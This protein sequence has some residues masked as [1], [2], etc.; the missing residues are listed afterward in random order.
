M[1]ADATSWRRVAFT[2]GVPIPCS[3]EFSLDEFERI[4]AGL[5]PQAMEDKWFIYYD[6]PF[7][8]LH[9][10]WTGEPV[11]RLRFSVGAGGAVVEEALL[12]VELAARGDEPLSYDAQLIEFLIGN[13]LLGGNKPFPVPAHMAATAGIYQHHVA[14]TSYPEEIAEEMRPRWRRWLRALKRITGAL[15]S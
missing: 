8:F 5:I 15:R 12:A 9:R 1:T 7:L 3:L 2:Q 11:Y 6:S 14:G 10:S 13:L 4:K